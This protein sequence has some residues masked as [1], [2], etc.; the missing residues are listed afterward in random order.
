MKKSNFVIFRPYQKRF[1]FIPKICIKD[2]IRNTSVYLECKEYVKYLGVFIDYKLSWKNCIDSVALKISKTI[3]LLSKLR[4]FVPTHTLINIY[5]SLIA[6]YLRNGLVA[7]GQAS[8]NELDKLRILQK[9]ALRFIFFA[10]RRDHAIPLFLKAK[11]LPIHCLHY[12]LLAE[13]MHDISND[14]VPSNLKEVF[15]P[16]A[17]VHLYNT[18]SSASKNFFI[19]KSRLEI[20]R[21]SF[22]RFGARLWNEL[23]TKLRM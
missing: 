14:L 6:P 21:N 1:P 11:I 3:G 9:R 17:K 22:S 7:W 12:K 23:P 4:H 15:L 13:T 20:K 18:R 19:K 10:N 8:K 16:T 5:N 2:P